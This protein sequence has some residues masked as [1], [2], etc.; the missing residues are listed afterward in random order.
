MDLLRSER[1][2]Q[3]FSCGQFWNG[4]IEVGRGVMGSGVSNLIFFSR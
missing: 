4:G 1:A 3:T 2:A